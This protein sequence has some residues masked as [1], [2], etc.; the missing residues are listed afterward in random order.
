MSQSIHTAWR[1]RI[2]YGPSGG[3]GGGGTNSTNTVTTSQQIPQFMQDQVQSNLDLANSIGAQPFPLYQGQLVA[4]FTP[5]QQAGQQA[6]IDASGA[7]QP[8]LNAATAQTAGVAGAFDP[9]TAQ[10]NMQGGAG[11]IGNAMGANQLSGIGAQT[12]GNALTNGSPANP[13][14][15]QQY[16]SPFVQAALAPQITA[17]NTQ[18]GMQQ[19]GIDQQ[20]TSA[21][22]FGDARQGAQSALAN[23]Y[24]NQSLAGLEAQGFNTAF[25]NAQNQALGQQQLG[26]GA[27][28]ALSNIGAQQQGIGIQG[29]QAL[30]QLGL[31]QGQGGLQSGAQLGSLAQMAQSL[32]LGG[33]NAIYNV[34]QQ[35]QQL[36]Q[37]Q[38]NTAYQQ[39]QNQVN[40][41]QQMLNLR[42]GAVAN[43]PYNKV[44]ATTLPNANMTSQGLGA[45]ASLAGMLGGGGG[46][47]APFGGQAINATGHA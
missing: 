27:G 45:F 33:A 4:P 29:G 26:V 24:G 21:N 5:T 36:A 35:Q 2:A 6:A 37:Q 14:V 18:L 43:Q 19:R 25:G 10:Q 8:G 16:M 46:A 12:I 42:L 9:A 41:P 44:D 7:Y 11:A 23:F 31:S 40:Y 28:T 22:A 34:G 20:A 32:G 13:G 15:I 1:E 38:D 3:G 17:M 30:G 39:F 47:Q